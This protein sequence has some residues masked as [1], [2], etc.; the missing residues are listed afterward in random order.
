MITSIYSQ[1]S[2]LDAGS[3]STP[4]RNLW[5]SRIKSGTLAMACLA[6]TACNNAD[7]QP[8]ETIETPEPPAYASASDYDK[9]DFTPDLA[10]YYGLEPGMDSEV[11]EPLIRTAFSAEGEGIISTDVKTIYATV[12]RTIIV[13][14][15]EG[16]LDDSIAGEQL[17][18][19]FTPV[20][21]LT[22]SLDFYGARIKC[23]RGRNT[24]DW[25][26][27]PCP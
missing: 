7:P 14:T 25:Q 17:Y 20:S 8:S 19:E 27:Q 11:A 21:P 12:G 23:A 6:L 4:R 15:V 24:T 18:A 22:N 26:T 1:V 16:L 3:P 10:R 2:A 9:S 13:A 5:R